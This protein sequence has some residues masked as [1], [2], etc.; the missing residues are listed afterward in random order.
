VEADMSWYKFTISND[1]IAPIVA[2]KIRE[3]FDQIW[4]PLS[5]PEGTAVYII[6]GE[7]GTG[8]NFYLTP[9]CEKTAKAL[10]VSCSAQACEQPDRKSLIFI[11]GDE[12]FLSA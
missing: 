2:Q 3:K 6:R 1:R 5:C 12:S 11:A 9:S 7:K 8:T 4:W 10:I